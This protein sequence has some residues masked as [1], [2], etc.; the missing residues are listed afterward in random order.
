MTRADFTS[1]RAEEFKLQGSITKGGTPWPATWSGAS[2]AFSAKRKRTDAVPVVTHSSGAG[3]VTL[4]ANATYTISVG[5]T[6]TSAFTKTEL[7]EFEVRL[8]EADGTVTVVAEGTWRV[9]LAVGP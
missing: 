9:R 4:G 8:T 2:L 1:E 6:D 5:A 3:G 7:L